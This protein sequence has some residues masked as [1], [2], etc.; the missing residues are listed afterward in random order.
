MKKMKVVIKKALE[1][2]YDSNLAVNWLD[3]EKCKLST[4]SLFVLK[5]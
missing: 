5:K 2:E 1:N 3:R 4:R